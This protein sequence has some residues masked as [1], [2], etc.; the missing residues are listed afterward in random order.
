MDVLRALSLVA[1][2]PFWTDD[3]DTRDWLRTAAAAVTI[4]LSEAPHCAV[5]VMLKA[6][7]RTD[8]AATL[9]PGIV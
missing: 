6:A 1:A 7:T 4:A 2:D 9:M 8:K 5:A 3:C